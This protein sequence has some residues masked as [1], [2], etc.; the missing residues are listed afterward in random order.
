MILA[1]RRYSKRKQ[2]QKVW[3]EALAAHSEAKA[4]GDTRD[5]SASLAK[6]KT[7]TTALLKAETVKVIRR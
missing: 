4:R 6:L 7:A 2:A 5:M 3:K 1:L